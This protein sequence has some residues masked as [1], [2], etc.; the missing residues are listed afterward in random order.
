MFKLIKFGFVYIAIRHCF[1][2]KLS[3]YNQ[4]SGRLCPTPIMTML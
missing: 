1:Q 2:V 3:F 4:L